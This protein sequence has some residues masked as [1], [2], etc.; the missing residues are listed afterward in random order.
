[1]TVEEFAKKYKKH[2]RT[3]INWVEK[4]WIPG[5]ITTPTGE[6]VIPE[7]A[8]EPYTSA[9]ARS[10]IKVYSSIIRGCMAGK[11]VCPE[12]FRM[13]AQLFQKYIGKLVEL[14]YVIEATIDDVTYY[15]P[16]VKCLE[17]NDLTQSDIERVIR[18]ALKTIEPVVEVFVK[19]AASQLEL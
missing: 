19:S 7:F 2:K 10:G 16:G 9:R 17:I 11:A 4:G 14:E 1:M 8:M 13:P 5:T 3:V 15:L 12:L 18:R 6:V